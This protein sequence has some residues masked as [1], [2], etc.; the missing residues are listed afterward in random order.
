MHEGER[1][2]TPELAAR[3]VAEQFPP[4][5]GLPVRALDVAGSDNVMLRLGEELVLRFP[6]VVSAVGSLEVEAQWLGWLA[7]VVPLAVPEV[8]ALGQPG[9]GYPWPWA[10]LRWVP[11]KDALVAPVEDLA[12]AEALAGVVLALQGSA[13]PDGL[14]VRQGDLRSRDGFLRQMVGRMTDEADP[15]KVTRAWEAVLGL[16]AWEGAPVVAHA[17]L[18]PL[19]LIVRDCA[20]VAVIDWGGMGAGDPALDLICGWTVLEAKGRAAFRQR[21]AVDDATWARGWAY[22]FS[23]AVMAAPYYRETN[24]ALREV[25]LR[26]LRR[27]MADLPW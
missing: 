13:V 15:R 7:E 22:A 11:G 12:A 27:C 16:P 9:A 26:T 5:A 25:M 1:V 21:L 19:N 14:P 2:V 20:L 23:K 8:V 3:L 24:P 18:H 10:V 4:W 17:D 6:R